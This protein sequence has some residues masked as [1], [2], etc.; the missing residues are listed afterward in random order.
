VLWDYVGQL[1]YPDVARMG[2]YHDDVVVSKSLNSPA[3]TKYALLSWLTVL[4][5]SI[6]LLRWRYGRYLVLGISWFLVGQSIESTVFSL[7][8][9]FEHRN[10]FPGIGL[11]L[12]IGTLFALLVKHW[13]QIK[14][15]LLVYLACYALWLSLLTGSQVQI[16]SSHPLL[17]LNHLNGHPGSFRANADM[18]VQMAK[19]GQF[20]AAQKYSAMAYAVN[21]AGER[22]GDHDI[23]DLALACIANQPV[24]PEQISRLGTINRERPFGSVD[25][26]QTLVRM[27]Q[28]NVC[29]DFDR[30]GF[31]DR[32]AEIF[33]GGDSLAS[34]SANI[35]L[36][37]AVLENALQRWQT[38]D[39]YISLFLTSSPENTQGLLMKLH[40]T[41]ALGKVAEADEVMTKLQSM[42]EQGKLTVGEQ[43]AL[44]LYLE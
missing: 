41:R 26:L 39:H 9:Y 37:L 30:V 5:G 17:I 25:T 28:D 2:L 42:Q 40:F 21:A 14:S 29:P 3:T 35:Y 23:R 27:L 32:M 11:F 31:A 12:L 33:L 38:A 7:E 13:P 15:P 24:E 1:V 44:S 19:L 16:W 34:A 36:G 43:Q 22:S 10:Y 4:L 18:A 20:E 8:L 6:V